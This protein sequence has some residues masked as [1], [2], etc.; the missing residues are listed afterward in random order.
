VWTPVSG[1]Y[2]TTDAGFR[3]GVLAAGVVAA[4]GGPLV[5]VL[6][7]RWLRFPG[8]ALL[9]AAVLIGWVLLASGAFTIEPS[10]LGTLWRLNAPVA[11]WESADGPDGPFWIAGGSPWAY[12]AY[13][14]GL[15]GLAAVAAMLHD[16]VGRRRSRL[17][18]AG[19]VLL[20]L[21]IACLL[22]A[23]APDPTRMVYL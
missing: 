3:L 1:W 13:L 6:I 8:A 20:V 4:V 9:G 14:V 2:V 23:A 5:G 10:R 18:G 15:C 12:V 16:A 7:G 11:G 17:L 19:A 22:L 21:T